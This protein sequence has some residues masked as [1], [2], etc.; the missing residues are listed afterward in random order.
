MVTNILVDAGFMVGLLSR[1]DSQHRWAAEQAA[2]FPP[3]WRTC[4]AALS[5]AFYLLGVRGTPALG[6]L[7]QREAV[8]IAFDLADNLE[9]ALKFMEKYAD[10]PASLADASLVRMSETL[11]APM[12]LTTDIDFRIYRRH[13]RQVVPC[14]TPGPSTA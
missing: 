10:V 5:E 13:G 8:V 6:A 7:L 11:A 12:L 14:V 9:A 1:R 4:E 2:R 3:P